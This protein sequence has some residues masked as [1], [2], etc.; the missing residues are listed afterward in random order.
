MDVNPCRLYVFSPVPPPWERRNSFANGAW[1]PPTH[2]SRAPRRQPQQRRSPAS[3][4]PSSPR[5]P[6]G[7]DSRPGPRAGPSARPRCQATPLGPLEGGPGPGRLRSAAG[8]S[9]GASGKAG[10]S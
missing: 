6:S 2:P 8:A 3:V 9:Q 10:A 7:A 1:K 4:L 5:L